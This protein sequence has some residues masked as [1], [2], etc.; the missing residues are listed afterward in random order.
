MI[1]ADKVADNY[2]THVREISRTS[3]KVPVIAHPNTQLYAKN[4]SCARFKT[5]VVAWRGDSQCKK[6]LTF[7]GQVDK[8]HGQLKAVWPRESANFP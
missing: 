4:S 6:Q 8:V 1:F 5:V 7:R 3:C 2:E